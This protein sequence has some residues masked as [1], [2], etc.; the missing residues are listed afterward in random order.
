MGTPLL[1]FFLLMLNRVC[2]EPQRREGHEGLFLFG[3]F[4]FWKKDQNQNRP[5]PSGG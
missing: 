3:L 4:W 5:S 1:G 2:F